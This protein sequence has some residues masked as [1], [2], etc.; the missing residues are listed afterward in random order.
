MKRHLLFFATLLFSISSFSQITIQ[1]EDLMHAGDTFLIHVDLNPSA[2]PDLTPGADLT[3]DFTSLTNDQTNFAT[4]SPNDELEFIDEFPL[5]QFHTY[6]PG[7]AYAGPGGGA[8]LENWGYMMS[9]TTTEGLF[10]EGFYSDYGMGYRSTFNSPAELLMPV[11]FTF[12]D[13]ET[14]VSYWEV[15]VDENNMD[16]DT[17]YRRDIDKDLEADAWGSITTAYGTFDVLR[18]HET[19][20]STDSIFG[21][22]GSTTFF[23]MEVERD[24]INKYYFWAKEIRQPVL[25]VHC[26]YEN[27]IERI[28]FLM[29]VIYSGIAETHEQ[30]ENINILPNPATNYINL[31][32]SAKSIEIYSFDGKLVKSIKDYQTNNKIDISQLKPGLYTVKFNGTQTSKFVKI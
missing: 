32:K 2:T 1:Q 18:V 4:Y 30:K 5:S 3:W 9:F 24:T 21:Y 23:T 12:T 15:I 14:N 7:F 20:I 6:G 17:L 10:V 19:G 29:G 22:I 16:Y 13:M 8:P 31:S 25:T 11:P 27:N 28:D 26:D